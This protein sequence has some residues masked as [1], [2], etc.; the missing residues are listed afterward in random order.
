LRRLSSDVARLPALT[1]VTAP[2]RI[3]SLIYEALL[4][5]AVLFAGTLTYLLF[6]RFF[7]LTLPRSLLQA[8]LLLLAAGYFIP[9]WVRGGQ[10]LP[11]K[12]WHIRLVNRDGNAISWRQALVRYIAAVVS[13]LLLGAGYLWAA[14]DKD[15]Q[16]LH[17]RLAGTCLVMVE[18]A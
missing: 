2:R 15:R 7:S 4:L 13:W 5:F 17:D 16:F 8:Y 14:L 10:T 11:M 1:V 9:Q 18:D 3:V 12:T 6:V